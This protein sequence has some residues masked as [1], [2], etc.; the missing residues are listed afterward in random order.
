MNGQR[1]TL[2]LRKSCDETATGIERASSAA[3][4]LRAA[5]VF[6]FESAYVTC[7]MYWSEGLVASQREQQ[8]VGLPGTV[9]AG[10]RDLDAACSTEPI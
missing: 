4:L 7:L 3:D 6:I 10:L 8:S 5:Y 9:C 2:Q 1:V